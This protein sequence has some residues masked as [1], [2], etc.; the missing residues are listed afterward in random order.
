MCEI[1]TKQ[2]KILFFIK[3]KKANTKKESQGPGTEWKQ[4][5]DTTCQSLVFCSRG[6][7]ESN[8]IA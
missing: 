3:K 8:D 4:A 7:Q 1:L 2:F 6:L 5:K